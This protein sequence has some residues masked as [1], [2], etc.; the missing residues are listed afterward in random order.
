MN[1]DGCEQ[2]AQMMVAAVSALFEIVGCDEINAR[3]PEQVTA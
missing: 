1:A 2:L 3:N